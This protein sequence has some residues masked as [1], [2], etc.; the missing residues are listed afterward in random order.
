MLNLAAPMVSTDRSR[1][2]GM[3]WRVNKDLNTI[4]FCFWCI[5]LRHLSSGLC[6]LVASFDRKEERYQGASRWGHRITCKA[7]TL[8]AASM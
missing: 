5:G 7:A 4:I 3:R 6:H 8:E 1:K 2:R